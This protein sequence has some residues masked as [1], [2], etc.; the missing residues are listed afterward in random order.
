MVVVYRTF[1]VKLGIALSAFWIC[2][3]YNTL[4]VPFSTAEAGGGL[5][6]RS[7]QTLDSQTTNRGYDL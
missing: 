2:F 4:V 7:N 5:R 6:I 1:Y 3:S